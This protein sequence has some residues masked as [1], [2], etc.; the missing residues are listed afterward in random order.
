M[1][2]DFNVAFKKVKSLGSATRPSFVDGPTVAANQ[3]MFGQDWCSGGFDEIQNNCHPGNQMKATQHLTMKACH[4]IGATATPIT[5]S[6]TV[7][8]FTLGMYS[9]R[10]F[11]RIDQ[12]IINIGWSICLFGEEKDVEV[13]LMVYKI[14]KA[15]KLDPSK[16]VVTQRL[17]SLFRKLCHV[18]VKVNHMKAKPAMLLSSG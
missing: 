9:F 5:I 11:L 8:N 12:D 3:T 18:R 2:S 10:S 17:S 13:N 14:A 4:V 16:F 7:S 15:Q 1:T 6:L